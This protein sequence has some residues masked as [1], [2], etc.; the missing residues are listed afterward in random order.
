MSRHSGTLRLNFGRWPEPASY[1]GV[2]KANGGWFG[3]ERPRELGTGP[4]RTE[5]AASAALRG[6]Y[7]MAK[8]LNDAARP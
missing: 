1:P 6:D 2:V 8:Q 5:D 4:W 7:A 3:V